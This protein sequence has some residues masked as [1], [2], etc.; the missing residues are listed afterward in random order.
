MKKLIK[1]SKVRRKKRYIVI[2]IFLLALSI[3]TYN[4]VLL[5]K[6]E[7]KFKPPGELIEIDGHKMHIYSIGDFNSSPTIVMTCGSGTASAY[8]EFANIQSKLST[9]TRTTVY[10]R[11][12]YGW[13]E[14]ATTVRDTEQ[15]VDDLRRLLDKSGEKPPYLF[16]AHSMGA[17]EVLLYTHKYPDEVQGIVLVDGTSPYKHLYHPEASISDLGV[18]AIRVLNK[19]GLIRI[20]L[21]LEIVPILNNRFDS[22][23]EEIKAIDKAMTY[24]NILNDMVL[25]EGNSLETTAEKMYGELDFGDIPV[26]LLVAD[27]SLQELPEWETSQNSLLE[28]SNNSELIVVKNT[29]HISIMHDSAE[30]IKNV[31]EEMIR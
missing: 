6:E 22:M 1:N 21:E 2:V 16:V 23:N 10:E 19:I 7:D 15:I 20:A 25:K 27:K 9:I 8:T 12:G 29:D 4:Y 11:P 17:M 26:V 3:P 24:K 28:L 18:K 5:K 13:S 30:I 31:I 14:Q